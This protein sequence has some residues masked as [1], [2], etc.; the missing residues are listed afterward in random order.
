MIVRIVKLRISQDKKEK[1]ISIFKE[2][3]HHIIDSKGC[4]KV[5]L[6]QDKNKQNI[7]FT[8]SHWESE[9]DLNAYRNSEV[10][11]KIWKATKATF[12]EPAEAWSTN[13]IA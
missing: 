3:K 11:G 13:I 12:C 5:E 4:I 8:Y 1:L 6:L 10:F 7:F 2:N 9:E